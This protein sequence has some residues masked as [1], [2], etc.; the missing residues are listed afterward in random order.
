MDKAYPCV[1]YVVRATETTN[2]DTDTLWTEVE[3]AFRLLLL[4][5]LLLRLSTA[6][7]AESL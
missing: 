1:L 5:R 7:T 6:R 4:R 3:G 2:Y